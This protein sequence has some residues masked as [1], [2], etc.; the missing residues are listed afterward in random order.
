[1]LLA[2]LVLGNLGL[3]LA[4]PLILR[5]FIDTATGHGALTTLTHIAALYLTIAA[6]MQV[7]RV[8]EAY[9]AED[10]AWLATN[11]LRVRAAQHCLHLDMTFHTI[12]LPGELIER[13]D[14]DAAYLAN[15]F[16]RFVLV[17]VGNAL[18]L[19]GVLAVLFGVDWRVGIVMAVYCV[20]GMAVLNRMRPLVLPRWKAFLQT[21]ADLFGFLEERLSGA[22]D[23]RANGAT[24]YPLRQLFERF[25]GYMRVQR[26]AMIWI[27]A[28]R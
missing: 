16:S 23:L 19:I 24:L 22:E 27:R 3:Q 4:G 18:L 6:V 15:F 14:G 2:V 20:V 13:I 25:R 21:F 8:A 10:V 5:S 11:L 9:V 1:V 26:T 7:V 17:I 28:P 12:H